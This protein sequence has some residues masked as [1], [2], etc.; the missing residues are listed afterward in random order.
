LSITTGLM[1]RAG[2]PARC[3]GLCELPL[4]TVIETCRVTGTPASEVEWE[5]AGLNHRGF[6]FSLRH[7][8]DDL[9]PRLPE[10][11]DG[12]TIFG[13]TGEEIDRVGA[14]PLKYFKL[15]T[16]A[17][18]AAG[19]G[20]A[21]FLTGL[22]ETIGR[23]LEDQ[24]GAPRSLGLRNLSWYDGAVVP[25][26]A[27]IF[28]DEGRRIVVN[29]I[30]GDGLVREFPA[31]VWRSGV[32]P[33]AVTPPPRVG[34]WLHRWCVHE[35]ALLEAVEAPDPHAIERALALDPAVPGDKV[36]EV[37]RAIWADHDN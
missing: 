18:S 19:P 26:I 10:M 15:S 7:R 31:R 20:R 24:T 17:C 23:E 12:Q 5:Y 32:E 2:A 13:V 33:V 34:P 1:I 25:M 3:V 16:T 22:K 4:A 11:L 21:A 30:A 29:R 36:R 35:R 8:G 37:A 28:A 27:A 14:L 9:L 6:V